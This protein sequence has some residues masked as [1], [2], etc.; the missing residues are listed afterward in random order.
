[1]DDKDR[2]C[3]ENLGVTDPRDD[4]KRIEETKGDLLRD[5]YQWILENVDF[6]RWYDDK[7]NRLLWVKGDP[8]KGKTILLCAIVNELKNSI[9]DADLLSFFFC[10]AADSRIN[11]AAAVLRG[12]IYLLVEQ[13]PSLVSHIRKKY[14]KQLFQD[15]N[16]WSA[17]SEIFTNI[18]EDPSLPSTYLIIDALDECTKDLE[19]L[20]EFIVLKSSAYSHVKWIVSSRN[21]PTVGEHL[22]TATRKISLCLELNEGSICPGNRSKDEM[23]QQSHVL[24]EEPRPTYQMSEERWPFDEERYIVFC[25]V[26]RLNTRIALIQVVVNDTC[27]IQL[28]DANSWK[29][30]WWMSGEFD[31]SIPCQLISFSEKGEYLLIKDRTGKSIHVIDVVSCKTYKTISFGINEG[32]YAMAFTENKRRV[33]LT[34]RRDKFPAER[35]PPEL[36][37]RL[38]SDEV[39]Q[40]IDDIIQYNGLS[41]HSPTIFYGGNG[42]RLYFCLWKSWDE[43]NQVA[44]TGWNV[45]TRAVEC[46]IT[47]PTNL[48]N[49]FHFSN[50][51]RS[52]YGP[53]TLVLDE[54][55]SI[56]GFNK[57]GSMKALIFSVTSNG[58]TPNAMLPC[59]SNPHTR[60]DGIIRIS[61]GTLRLWNNRSEAYLGEIDFR[62]FEMRQIVIVVIREGCER[63]SCIFKNGKV[64]DFE[65]V[66]SIKEK[67]ATD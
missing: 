46:R 13:R 1:M 62:S 23:P 40:Y 48:Q 5:S 33:G 29:K 61:E 6:Q 14:S 51:L 37:S 11:N 57:N 42:S 15:T 65:R 59:V 53:A 12:L 10:Q 34:I 28:W 25:L 36:R 64:V 35:Y 54:F 18:L 58:Q 27:E 2:Q 22:D 19:K 4:K 16:S 21:C 49:S 56:C 38:P 8:G 7:Q 67:Q 60:E 45:E 17:L 63:L 44:V 26:N 47:H 50:D 66:H 24:V 52:V 30:L 32:L 9:G 55:I 31:T 41:G 39:D 43:D 20:L 3:L